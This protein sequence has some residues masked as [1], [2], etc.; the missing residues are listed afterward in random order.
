LLKSL[1]KKSPPPWHLSSK[2]AVLYV[3]MAAI[4]RALN[5][6]V[7]FE[8]MPIGRITAVR[9]DLNL[10]MHLGYLWGNKTLRALQVSYFK[11]DAAPF[12]AKN[13]TVSLNKIVVPV[14]FVASATGEEVVWNPNTM[15]KQVQITRGR[16]YFFDWDSSAATYIQYSDSRDQ[17]AFG[18]PNGYVNAPVG[19][20]G[21]RWC[22]NDVRNEA[23]L[24][25]TAQMRN[26][27]LNSGQS[28]TVCDSGRYSAA[29]ALT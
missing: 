24:V 2:M 9:N 22:K 23:F 11:M 14:N 21:G 12:L 6:D 19:S 13:G 10:T 16:S 4:F 27:C 20:E 26:A 18:C 5:A 15:P 3:E 1:I 29:H 28:A 7:R 17:M 25:P 8:S